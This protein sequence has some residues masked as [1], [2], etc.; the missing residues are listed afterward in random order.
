MS[1]D[2]GIFDE[3]LFLDFMQFR[4]LVERECVRLI[5]S[6]LTFE[7]EKELL[8][9]TGAVSDADETDAVDRVYE[10][11]RCLTRISGNGAYFMVFQSFGKMMRSLISEHYENTGEV[12]KDREKIKNLTECIIRRDAEGADEAI[13]SLLNCASDY[14]K[15]K[16]QKEKRR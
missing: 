3:K 14:L 13:T 5:V 10:Y 4:I 15:K 12:K 11:H 9:V 2:R 7:K 6:S 8:S 1:H 16:I